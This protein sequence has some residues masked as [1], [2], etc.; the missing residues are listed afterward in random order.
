[1]SRNRRRHSSQDDTDALFDAT[2]EAVSSQ[3]LFDAPNEAVMWENLA[4]FN[5]EAIFNAGAM[6]A[7]DTPAFSN[8]I[9][10]IAYGDPEQ[11]IYGSLDDHYANLRLF[12]RTAQCVVQYLAPLAQ[13]Q[14]AELAEA[15]HKL[16][17]SDRARE[18]LK[19]ENTTLR[20]K[21]KAQRRRL[22]DL[23]AQLHAMESAAYPCGVCSK[24]FET[25]KFMLEHCDRHSDPK[26]ASQYPHDTDES[27][28]AHAH[29]ARQYRHDMN[30]G[31]AVE[32]GVQFGPTGTL[33]LSQLLEMAGSHRELPQRENLKGD[34]GKLLA[35][36]PLVESQYVS[37]PARTVAKSVRMPTSPDTDAISET[38]SMVS[39]ETSRAG[40]Q[41]L[42]TFDDDLEYTD[43]VQSPE[44]ATEDMASTMMAQSLKVGMPESRVP[45]TRPESR[46][47]H[48]LA[49][50][51]VVEEPVETVAVS[52]RSGL[53]QTVESRDEAMTPEAPVLTPESTLV[54]S[55][56][57]EAKEEAKESERAETMAELEDMA[58]IATRPV[59]EVD[60]AKPSPEEP[61]PEAEV[62]LESKAE[63]K[64][65]PPAEES[66]AELS[67]DLSDNEAEVARKQRAQTLKLK[68]GRPLFGHHLPLP[69]DAPVLKP[70]TSIKP[71]VIGTKL[72]MPS[73]QPASKKTVKLT[74]PEKGVTEPETAAL[75]ASTAES[76]E[77]TPEPAKHGESATESP[78]AATLE[79]SVPMP[80]VATS[81]QPPDAQ[82]MTR[83]TA[84]GWGENT[85]GAD[86]PARLPPAP[87]TASSVPGTQPP[88][89]HAPS[90][91]KSPL[92][93]LT[94]VSDDSLF[95]SESDEWEES[96]L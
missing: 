67:S 20:R 31:P 83:T 70:L 12:Y 21:V 44:S 71:L 60:P 75:A 24:R 78:L 41:T 45:G 62:K 1:M 26:Y 28:S 15:T 52:D 19:D 64:P 29:F 90:P 27:R 94:P 77:S 35:E 48:G 4:S 81:Y 14:A 37:G 59:P 43:S 88:N 80:L 42:D 58:A 16:G 23:E 36:R 79:A 56:E 85:K 39:D 82:A 61:A 17:A 10:D 7:E 50:T 65:E 40:A 13:N 74:L 86:P 46:P 76:E 63:S 69:V 84:K 96:A 95:L 3:V 66:D 8:V 32:F 68:V 22:N 2:K 51:I 89:R 93:P 38:E 18:K 11:S 55:D 30:R 73:T 25:I 47:A 34:L 91:S 92:S 9:N 49:K 87:L 57:A 33:G 53:T 6:F 5:V 54:E 72:S